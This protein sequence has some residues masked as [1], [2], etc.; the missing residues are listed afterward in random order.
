MSPAPVV[1]RE[2]MRTMMEVQPLLVKFPSGPVAMYHRDGAVLSCMVDA[3]GN[4]DNMMYTQPWTM[5]SVVVMTPEGGVYLESPTEKL[6]VNPLEYPQEYA[7]VVE[8]V[9]SFVKGM[10][11]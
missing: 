7:M 8:T 9:E 3:C 1:F 11:K 6:C 4:V 10:R 2:A 5:G